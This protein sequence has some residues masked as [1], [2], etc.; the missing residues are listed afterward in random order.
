MNVVN[1]HSKIDK[2]STANNDEIPIV[3]IQLV[4]KR[5]ISVLK[6]DNNKFGLKN[7]KKQYE[8]I[9]CNPANHF[10]SLLIITAFLGKTGLIINA[11]GINGA[12]TKSISDKNLCSIFKTLSI[13]S[14]K[15]M[16][17]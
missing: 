14:N 3:F 9:R 1:K 10:E 13:Y 8:Y 7:N 17:I 16:Q 5:K 4:L 6:D 15:I 12:K 11:V 2:P